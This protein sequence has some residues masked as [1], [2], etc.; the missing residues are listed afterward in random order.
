MFIGL[1]AYRAI[2]LGAY[3]ALGCN[4]LALGVWAWG[5]RGLALGYHVATCP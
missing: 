5:C 1:R 3:R 4:V 2:G